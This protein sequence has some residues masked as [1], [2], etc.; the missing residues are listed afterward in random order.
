MTEYTNAVNYSPNN[1]A[2]ATEDFTSRDGRFFGEIWHSERKGC[3]MYSN[4]PGEFDMKMFES[5]VVYLK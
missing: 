1:S 2:F 3:G 4:V 5:A